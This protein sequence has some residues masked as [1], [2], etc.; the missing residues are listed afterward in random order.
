[1]NLLTS[2]KELPNLGWAIGP[3]LLTMIAIPFLAA[4][5]SG[6]P[7][8]EEMLVSTDW[9]AK[10]LQD[11]NLIVLCIADNE[12]FYSSDHIPGARMILVSQI[13]TTRSGVPNELPSLETLQHV[14]EMAGVSNDSHIILYGERSGLLATRA[15]FTLDYLSLGDRASLLDGGIEKWRAER[16]QVS[17]AAPAVHA[18]KLVV[19]AHPEILVTREQMSAYSRLTSPD[20]VLIDS[21]PRAEYTGEKLSENVPKRGHIPNAVGLYWRELLQGDSLPELKSGADLQ[22]LFHRIGASPDKEVVT[23]CRTGMQSSFSYFVA[24]Y[25][26]YKTKM[27]DSSFYDWSRSSLPVEP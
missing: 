14:F 8:R 2:H 10:H 4:V 9:L 16:R 5:E 21:R 15:Y 11:R 3:L 22:Q 20:A 27:Y 25:L 26:G 7:A 24:R 19:R 18:S 1:V 6:T 23:Y 12:R 13:V 17:T